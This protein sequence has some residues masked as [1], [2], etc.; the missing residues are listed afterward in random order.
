MPKYLSEPNR[1]VGSKIQV[2]ILTL[3]MKALGHLITPS[4]D[5]RGMLQVLLVLGE[6]CSFV[7]DAPSKNPS[8][9]LAGALQQ[10][11]VGAF[12]S[13]SVW[14]STNAEHCCA[15]VLA[16]LQRH[17]QT[18]TAWGLLKFVAQTQHLAS[19]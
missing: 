13:S 4:C 14:Y 10:D 5:G 7:R 2:L 19:P 11:W 15:F 16:L 12:L 8:P 1:G 18:G 17:G 3:G 9:R 6:L